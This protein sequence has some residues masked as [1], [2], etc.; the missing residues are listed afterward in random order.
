MNGD[1]D[2]KTTALSDLL[3]KALNE[4]VIWEDRH[5]GDLEYHLCDLMAIELMKFVYTERAQAVQEFVTMISTQHAYN[6]APDPG[7]RFYDEGLNGWLLEIM[8]ADPPESYEEYL[9]SE[10]EHR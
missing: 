10:P 1:L 2:P 8:Q 7:Q 4:N 9:A 5:I 6:G 3:M